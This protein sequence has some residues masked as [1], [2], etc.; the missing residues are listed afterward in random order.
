MVEIFSMCIKIVIQQMKRDRLV[1]WLF[2]LI[3]SRENAVPI[4][5]WSDDSF[6]KII[7]SL[8]DLDTYTIYQDSSYNLNNMGAI[9]L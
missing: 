8:C 3:R 1:K 7:S 6:S 4:N 9:I 5:N 2:D